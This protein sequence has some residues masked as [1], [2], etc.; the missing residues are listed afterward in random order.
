MCP[1]VSPAGLG[2]HVW[3]VWQ[4]APWQNDGLQMWSTSQTVGTC[5]STPSCSG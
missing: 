1:V 5:W 2:G 4:D 3:V